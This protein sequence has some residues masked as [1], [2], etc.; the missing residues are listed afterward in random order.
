MVTVLPIV[1]TVDFDPD[2]LNLGSG[3]EWVTAYIELPDGYDVAGI[4]A[5]SVLLNGEVSAVTDPKYGFV[6]DKRYPLYIEWKAIPFQLNA[7][8]S[9]IS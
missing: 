8:F 5:S 3:G 1:A 7:L 4:D 6:K 2:T 9:L